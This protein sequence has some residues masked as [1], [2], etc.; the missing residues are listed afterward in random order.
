V[1]HRV[2]AAELKAEN[3]VKLPLRVSTRHPSQKEQL[4]SDALTLRSDL[5]RLAA[6][7]S[8]ATGEY[9]RPILLIQAERVDACEP[10]RERLVSE[11]GIERDR[12]KISTGS[13][14][15]LE[16]IASIINTAKCQVRH[17][18]TVQ[19]LREG[20][21]CPFAY[22]LCSLQ[23]TRSATAIEQ[24]VGRVLRL[25]KSEAQAASRLELRVCL[26]AVAA[27]S[28]GAGR[29]AKCYGEQWLHQGRS[30]AHHHSVPA[31]HAADGG[32]SRRR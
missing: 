20:W 5:E 24:I 32:R 9:L 6:A 19:K 15:E 21:D 2:S 16:D 1:L 22:V 26:L 27:D 3:M 10:L 8:Q 30:R 31:R 17:I 11:Y 12:I 23:E 4:L 29:A 25:P 14:E 7:E 28:N 13:K 18:I